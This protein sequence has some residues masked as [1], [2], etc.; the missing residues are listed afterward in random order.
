MK[1][2]W[3]DR[4]ALAFAVAGMVL[5]V[6]T[7]IWRVNPVEGS[8]IPRFLTGNLVGMGVLWILL[9]TCM[10]VWIVTTVLGTVILGSDRNLDWFPHWLH[11]F[12]M[13][14]VLFQGI[15]YFLIGKLVSL[16]VRKLARGKAAHNN[17]L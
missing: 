14:R 9:I 13:A 12:D 17:V 15:V 11:V 6:L 4:V 2:F 16:C 3:K 1:N 10:P 7:I 8:V 5:M